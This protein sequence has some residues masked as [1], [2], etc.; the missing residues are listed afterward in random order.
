VAEKIIKG[1]KP[2]NPTPLMK[3]IAKAVTGNEHA[4]D[5]VDMFDLEEI[6]EIADYLMVYYEA[7]KNGD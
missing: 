3:S 1:V 6:K 5:S 7:H 2:N 4:S